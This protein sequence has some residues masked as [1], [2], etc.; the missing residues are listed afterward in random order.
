MSIIFGLRANP[1]C[2][3]GY[4]DFKNKY[5]TPIESG[6][7]AD[8]TTAELFLK[9]KLSSELKNVKD[10]FVIRRTKDLIADQMPKKSKY[11]QIFLMIFYLPPIG[12]VLELL[13]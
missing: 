10:K 8:A 6:Q 4:K 1:N 5:A 12:E 7:K 2:L 9:I 13:Y 11:F 3:G